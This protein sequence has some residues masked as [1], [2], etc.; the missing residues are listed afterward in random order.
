MTN[1]IQ[2][3][4]YDRLMR[5][6]GGIIGPGSK[7]SEVLT[8]LFPTLDVERVPGELLFLSGWQLGMGGGVLSAGAGNTA[9]FQLVN[10]ADSGLLVVV[11]R[12]DFASNTTQTVNVDPNNTL[13]VSAPG[14]NVKRDTRTGVGA[15]VSEVRTSIDVSVTSPTYVLQNLVN[16]PNRIWDDNGIAVLSPGFALQIG[17]TATA[18]TFRVGFLWRE[19]V[20]ELSELAFSG[21]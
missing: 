11:T 10:P 4:R 14:V 2:Q 6:V 1:E 17:Q 16:T 18:G 9:K 19:R 21:G 8:E 12:I 20:A 5:R 7:V 3:T 15:T 13:F